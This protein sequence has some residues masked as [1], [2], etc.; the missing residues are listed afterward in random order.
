MGTISTWK[1]L[2]DKFLE[3]FFTHT[4]FQKRKSEILSFKQHESELL[5]IWLLAAFL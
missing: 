2:E 3:R 4:L 5:D 1:K